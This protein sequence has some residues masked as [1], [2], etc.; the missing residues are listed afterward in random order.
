VEV[1]RE[2][3]RQ[4]S[5]GRYRG[6]L[7]ALIGYDIGRCSRSLGIVIIVSGDGDFLPLVR[8]LRWQDKCVIVIGPDGDATNDDL[9]IEADRFFSISEVSKAVIRNS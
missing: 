9:K 4:T 8:R 7:D 1:E 2:P 6:N 5:N 3:L